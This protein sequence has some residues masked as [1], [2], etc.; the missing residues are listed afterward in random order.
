MRTG[1]PTQF[2]RGFHPSPIL[3]ISHYED[4]IQLYEEIYRHLLTP[5]LGTGTM[6]TVGSIFMNGR[7]ADIEIFAN[8][9]EFLLHNSRRIR[10][11]EQNKFTTNSEN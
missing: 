8:S 4:P 7:S 11:I 5:S 3:D 2:S 6:K 10:R 9:F 1:A